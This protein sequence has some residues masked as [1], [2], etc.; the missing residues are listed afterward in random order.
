VN[1]D[2]CGRADAAE[3]FAKAGDA[4]VRCHGCGLIYLNPQPS[5]AELAAIYGA[6]YYDAWGIADDAG[7]VERLKRRTFRTLFERLASRTGC[8]G[9]RLLD[10]G[11]ATGFLLEE[12]RAQGFDPYGVEMSDFSARVA[13]EKIGADRIHRGTLEDASFERSGFDVIVMSD[14]LEH[15]RSPSALVRRAGDLLVPSGTLVVV[16]PDV[17]S[18]SRR[19]LGKH[20]TDFKREHL[21]YF[22]RSTLGTMLARAGFDVLEARAFPKYLDLAYVNRQLSTYHTPF[23]SPLVRG[24]HALAPVPLRRAVVPVFAGSMMVI[25]RR[26]TA[27]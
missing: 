5:D 23:F 13:R 7:G 11:C 10:V 26:T 20:W 24:L 6:S 25:A 2:L 18:L 17:A 1:C 19:V 8:R 15:V 9:G 27:A 16:A 22:D 21:F 14:L 3:L 4:Y 12:A